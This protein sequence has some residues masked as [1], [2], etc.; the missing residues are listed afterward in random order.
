MPV[1]AIIF[2]MDGILVDS[3]AYWFQSRIDFA[4]DRGKT[5]TMDDQRAAMG[6][7]T[8]EWAH[9]MQERLHLDD[10]PLQ[11]IMDDVTDRVI[12]RLEARLPLL[13]GAVEAVH[14][15]ASLHRVALASGSPTRVIE[16]VM[17]LTGLDRV[18]E[19]MVF[20]DTIARGKPHPDIYLETAA[21]LGVEPRSCVGIED[22]GNGVRAL[23]AAGMIGV[24]V[25]SPGFPLAPEVL[26]LAQYHLPDLTHFTPEFIRRIDAE[27]G[28]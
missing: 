4:A 17:R 5:W 14:T 27:H 12:A 28:S 21:R 10:L 22:S 1:Q 3:E 2:D 26:A 24:A 23:H 11:A 18:F 9:V 19:V 20:G 15:A 25:P 7:N 6:R 13:P 16:T 8:V